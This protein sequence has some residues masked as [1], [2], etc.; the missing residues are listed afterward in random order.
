MAIDKNDFRVEM[1]RLFID[2]VLSTRKSFFGSNR[3]SVS[4]SMEALLVFAAILQAEAA[5]R[6]ITA[7]KAALV[8]GLPRT[9]ISRRVEL[10]IKH[11]LVQRTGRAL[12]IASERTKPQ[13]NAVRIGRLVGQVATSMPQ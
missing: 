1:A 4:A 5:R 10:L 2:W 11:K 3:V 13:S 7:H 12:M 9:T 6:P 8:L